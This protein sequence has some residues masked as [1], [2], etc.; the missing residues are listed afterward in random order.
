MKNILPPR[1]TVP[2]ILL[3]YYVV[4]LILCMGLA[5]VLDGWIKWVLVAC[6]FL[7]PAANLTIGMIQG[8]D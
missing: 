3:A 4:P 7:W 2:A 6:G 5:L 8:C 1:V